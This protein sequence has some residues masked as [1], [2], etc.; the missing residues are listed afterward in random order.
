MIGVWLALLSPEQEDRVLT[1]KMDPQNGDITKNCLLVTCHQRGKDMTGKAW[2]LEHTE[3]PQESYRR[4]KLSRHQQYLGP[5]FDALC[6]RF[7]TARV[8]GFIRSRIL[9]NRLRRELAGV[10]EAVLA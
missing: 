2:R 1:G 6:G 4:R 8:S 3:L 5:Q 9:R 10:R 7:G